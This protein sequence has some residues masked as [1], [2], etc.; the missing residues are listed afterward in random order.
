MEDLAG[1]GDAA[2]RRAS[3]GAGVTAA[4]QSLAAALRA[5]AIWIGGGLRAGM[6]LLAAGAARVPLLAPIV[7]RYAAHYDRVERGPPEKLSEKT[8]RFFQRW[9]IKFSAEY[10]E[11]KEREEAA[12]HSLATVRASPSPP[13]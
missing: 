2:L 11:A 4:W 6:E 12:Q 13:N 5:A 1:R 7:A 3:A 10:Y 9:S 8:A